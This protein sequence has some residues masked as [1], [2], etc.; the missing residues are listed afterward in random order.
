VSVSDGRRRQDDGR[1]R[2]LGLLPPRL[3]PLDAEQER[4]A[5]DALANLL[6]PLL[7]AHAAE[8][9]DDGAAGHDAEPGGDDPRAA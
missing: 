1:D 8:S 3:V 5:V 6:A 4:R 7:A 2:P 9:G